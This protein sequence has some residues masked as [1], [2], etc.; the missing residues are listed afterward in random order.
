MSEPT[1]KSQLCRWEDKSYDSLMWGERP[2]LKFLVFSLTSLVRLLTGFMHIYRDS[3][4]GEDQ[5]LPSGAKY[6]SNV[7]KME[8]PFL[9]SIPTNIRSFSRPIRNVSFTARSCFQEKIS[10]DSVKMEERKI[11]VTLQNREVLRS[12]S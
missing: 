11:N 4:L 1:G 5:L 7:C 2:C 8:G 10:L 12:I 9:A 3:N 6:Y